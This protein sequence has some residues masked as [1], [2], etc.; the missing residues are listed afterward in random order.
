VKTGKI[1][2][3]NR[4][5]QHFRQVWLWI[6]LISMSLF[7]IWGMVQQLILGEPF[8]NNP[9][10]D[11]VLIII[12]PIFGFGFPIFFYMMNLTTEVRDDGIYFRFFPVHFSFRKIALEDVR[13]Y[14]VLTYNALKEYGGWGIRYGRKGKAYSVSGNRGVQ[15]ELSNGSQLL[16]GSQKPEELA[17]ALSLALR[18]KR[19]RL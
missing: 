12:V 4:E 15:L 6:F 3:L 5:V 2:L 7:C 1:N 13:R 19:L 9:A 11:I 17:E 10:P 14:E 18:G 8:G 16:I